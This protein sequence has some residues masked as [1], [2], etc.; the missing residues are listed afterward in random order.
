MTQPAPETD[1][2]VL[3]LALDQF[4]RG[5][6]F[7]CHETLERLWLPA[8]PPV[9]AVYQGLI[10]IAAGLHHLA[11][12]NRPGATALL[13]RGVARLGPQPH[14]APFG[15]DLPALVAAVTALTEQIDGTQNGPLAFDPVN[16]P[17]ISW[18]RS[19]PG[20][21]PAAGDHHP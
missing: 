19:G 5:E 12:G 16:G 8:Q 15:L 7:A 1:T 11:R 18:E 21:S 10:Q 2:D 3:R 6:Y 13:R 9:R 4:N 20:D 17:R 14:P